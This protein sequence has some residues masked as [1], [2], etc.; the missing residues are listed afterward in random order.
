MTLPQVFNGSVCA[1]HV[2]SRRLG[3]QG[4]CSAA[5]RQPHC[6]REALELEQQLQV[7]A[8]HHAAPVSEYCVVALHCACTV[9]HFCNF[10]GGDVWQPPLQL[11]GKNI[12]VRSP[13][14]QRQSTH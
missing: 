3:C 11:L 10:R 9:A 12:T 5:V 6:D 7:H 8:S 14:S 1:R 2:A 13:E 4:E